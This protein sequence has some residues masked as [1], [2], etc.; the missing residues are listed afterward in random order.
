MKELALVVLSR[1]PAEETLD[2][3]RDTYPV[4]DEIVLVDSSERSV[5]KTLAEQKRKLG[6]KKLKI[7][8]AVPTGLIEMFLP[9]AM[10]KCESKWILNLDVGERINDEFKTDIRKIINSCTCSAFWIN[11][12]SY[13]YTGKLMSNREMHLRLYKKHDTHYVGMIHEHP[14]IRGAEERLPYKYSII[15]NPADLT[16]GVYGGDNFKR[17]VA[18]EMLI[19]RRSYAHFLK[20][21]GKR[22]LAFPIRSYINLKLK[23]SKLTTESELTRTDYGL[24]AWLDT[25]AWIID[26]KDPRIFFYLG[27]MSHN[28]RNNYKKIDMFFAVEPQERILQYGISRDIEKAG[29]VAEYLKLIQ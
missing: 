12:R 22:G 2:V 21:L 24:L 18:I 11:K 4:V 19:R 25:L 1:G 28:M 3:I 29:G 7:Y 5:R 23:T 9:F 13:T 27:N 15:H 14:S 8:F 26:S 6:L 16:G 20:L 10:S 17:Y